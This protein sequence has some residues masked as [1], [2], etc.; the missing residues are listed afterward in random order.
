MTTA[1]SFP[2]PE[3]TEFVKNNFALIKTGIMALNF[4][5]KAVTLITKATTGISVDIPM[6]DF[7]IQESMEEYFDGMDEYFEGKIGIGDVEDIDLK[8]LK[9]QTDIVR[10]FVNSSET[11]LDVQIKNPTKHLTGQAYEKLKGFLNKDQRMKAVN[12]AMEIIEGADKERVWV[13]RSR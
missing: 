10:K 4:T 3:P 12:Q 6:P 11:N 1:V 7:A 8:K 13:S 5:G 9:K 2:I